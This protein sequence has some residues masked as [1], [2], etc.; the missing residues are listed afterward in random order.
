MANNKPRNQITPNTRKEMKPRGKSKRS[1]ILDSI[2]EKGLLEVKQ[3]ASRVDAE[4]AVF[5]FMADA[6]FN[7]TPDTTVVSN[8]CLNHLMNK[9]WASVKPSAECIEY[10]FD[11]NSKPHEQASQ[12]LKGVSEGVIPPDIGSNMIAS[13][14]SMLKITEVT[15]LQDRIDALEAALNG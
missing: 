12:I 10:E 14:A 13:I 1:L 5:G 9:G 3:G 15:E 8:A 7:P 6:A 2:I 4:K 11:E